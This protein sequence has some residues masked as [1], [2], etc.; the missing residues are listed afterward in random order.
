[1]ADAPTDEDKVLIRDFLDG[2]VHGVVVEDDEDLFAS[3]LVNSLFAVQLVM[4]VE[5]TYGLRASGE[6]LDFANFRSIDAI[7][8]FVARKKALVGGDA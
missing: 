2:H 5:R 7:A 1:M 3:G 4:W 8:G 6:D